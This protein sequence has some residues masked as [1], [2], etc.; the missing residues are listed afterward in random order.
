MVT[1]VRVQDAEVVLL[2]LCAELHYKGLI[3][4]SAVPVRV[5]V[6]VNVSEEVK[7]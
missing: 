2:H 7:G 6:S 3:V 5:I 1:E 4:A